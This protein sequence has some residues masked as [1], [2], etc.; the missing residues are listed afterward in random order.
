VCSQ[1]TRECFLIDSHI[2][3]RVIINT[4]PMSRTQPTK[5]DLLHIKTS[6]KSN[7]H[8]C[9]SATYQKQP[10]SSSPNQLTQ[11]YPSKPTKSIIIR[12]IKNQKKKETIWFHSL[13]MTRKVWQT[14]IYIF[15]FIMVDYNDDH[16]FNNVQMA[17]KRKWNLTII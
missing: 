6:Q 13:S 5:P 12:N 4:P 1:F 15:F 16:N 14:Y 11:N 9:Q 8:D 7:T 17:Y 10:Q 2:I 3:T